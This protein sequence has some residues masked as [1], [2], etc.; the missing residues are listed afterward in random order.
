MKKVV[1]IKDERTGCGTLIFIFGIFIASALFGVGGFA[2]AYAPREY[3]LL[4]RGILLNIIIGW[5]G[6]FF[7]GGG[8]ILILIMLIDELLKPFKTIARISENGVYVRQLLGKNFIPWNNISHFSI[9]PPSYIGIF[10]HST[11]GVK[12]VDNMKTYLTDKIAYTR[13]TDTLTA[14]TM[15]ANW[16]LDCPPHVLLELPPSQ[17]PEDVMGTLINYHAKYS[18]TR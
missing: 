16:N 17:K 10:V 14:N 9:L 7:F 6:V 4:G 3:A 12:G 18:V 8:A 5:V 2:I 13:A 11:E 15:Q 1:T